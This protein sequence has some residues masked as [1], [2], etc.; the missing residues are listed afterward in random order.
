MSE[1]HGKKST[2]KA[3]RA[4]HI[5]FCEGEPHVFATVEDGRHVALY[6]SKRA[7]RTHY[8]D[9]RRVIIL[10]ADTKEPIL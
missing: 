1:R 7:A 5:G 10:D 2:A 8:E 4:W 3:R 9:A 6:P